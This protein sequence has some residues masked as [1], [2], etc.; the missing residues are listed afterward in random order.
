[1]HYN[2]ISHGKTKLGTYRPFKIFML[3]IKFVNNSHQS[4]GCKQYSSFDV[5][6]NIENTGE[7][8][9]QA[10]PADVPSRIYAADA[11]FD[12]PNV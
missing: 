1:M 3:K 10:L 12:A 11:H 6:R 7:Y 2:I 9:L 8:N 5:A 4:S